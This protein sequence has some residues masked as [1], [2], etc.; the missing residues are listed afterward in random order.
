MDCVGKSGEK[1]GKERNNWELLKMSRRLMIVTWTR[2][3]A[4]EMVGAS[5]THNIV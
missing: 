2:V 3:I 4:V 1:T 5:W